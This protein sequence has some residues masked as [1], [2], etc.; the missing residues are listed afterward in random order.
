MFVQHA[1]CVTGGA[2]HHCQVLHPASGVRQQPAD[3]DKLEDVVKGDAS[4]QRTVQGKPPADPS[5]EMLTL[6][7]TI[8][9]PSPA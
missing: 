5:K 8:G 7:G 2:L 3:A 4:Y 9:I 1:L 6:Q